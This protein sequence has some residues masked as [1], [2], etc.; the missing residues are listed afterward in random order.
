MSRGNR[1][2]Q[3]PNPSG[4]CMCGCGRKAPISKTTDKRYG[5]YYGLPSRYIKGHHTRTRSS[6]LANYVEESRGY[7]TPCWIW[8][9]CTDR[10]GYGLSGMGK[11]SRYVH[12]ELYIQKF[13]E[14]PEP[15]QLDHLC[16]VPACVNPDHL[17]PVTSA[18]NTRRGKSA[19][20]NWELVDMIR[21]LD[22]SVTSVEIATQLGIHPKTVRLARNGRTWKKAA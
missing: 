21:S 6:K 3:E 10:K 16:R 15:L 11:R 13:G 19:K 17:E 1:I 4:L 20:L 9:G 8:Q 12:I 14:I 7:S 5:T 2:I 18:E 22:P